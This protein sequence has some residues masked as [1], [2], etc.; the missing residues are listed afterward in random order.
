M[1]ASCPR[2][3]LL[4]TLFTIHS[5]AKPARK[6]DSTAAL[7]PCKLLASVILLAM[8]FEQT[9]ETPADHSLTLEVPREIP[10]GKA[11]LTFTPV[12]SRRRTPSEAIE[13][14]HGLA[15]RLGCTATSDDFL[16][17]RRRDRELEDEQYRRLYPDNVGKGIICWTLAP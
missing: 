13:Y 14:C 1:T 7:L 5:T 15:K 9:V 2:S 6:N 12:P 4:V 17:Q 8:T 3:H 11:I 16:E 10:A